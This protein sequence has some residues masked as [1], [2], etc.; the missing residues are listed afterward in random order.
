MEEDYIK[1]IHLTSEDILGSH[2]LE[3]KLDLLNIMF[4]GLGNKMPEHDEKH[5]LHRLLGTLLSEKLKPEEKLEI[6]GKEYEIPIEQSIRK[7]VDDMYTLTQYL[8]EQAQARADARAEARIEEKIEER[9]K[10]RVEAKLWAKTREVRAE[11]R[12]E[13]QAE[14]E[15]KYIVSMYQ[16]G[17]TMEQ[18]TK[19]SKKTM[20]EV[21]KILE[22]K[23]AV[24]S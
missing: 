10:E 12:A 18:I 23:K 13:A 19:V 3:G 11:A 14:A 21:K 1:H 2:R 9:V 6:I 16:N 15:N 22:G 7:E 8:E 4:I 20:E 24:L 5:K 17:F